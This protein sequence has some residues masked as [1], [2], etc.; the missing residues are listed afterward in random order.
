[1]E[2]LPNPVQHS[3]D[4]WT[5]RKL[6][7]FN[8]SHIRQLIQQSGP[9]Y[10]YR[11]GGL[12]DRQEGGA[13]EGRQYD[14]DPGENWED[15]SNIR[16]P[17]I[18]QLVRGG[19]EA[20]E[21]AAEDAGD[22]GSASGL[23]GDSLAFTLVYV[24]VFTVT[25]L[26]VGVRL[27]RRWRARQ[28]RARSDAPPSPALPPCG[29]PQCARPALLPYTGL[30]AAWIPELLSLQSG[31]PA[32]SPAPHS[33]A[34]C[35]G[36]CSECRALARPPPSYTKLFYD[37]Q[38]PAYQDTIVIKEDHNDGDKQEGRDLDEEITCSDSCV[39]VMEIP[40]TGESHEINLQGEEE[41]QSASG[42]DDSVDTNA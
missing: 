11:P 33:T 41:T 36:R 35:R 26:Y 38:P 17:S 18:E 5:L 21:R 31:Q 2:S 9:L 19:G 12:V 37:E 8:I 40:E 13:E 10:S 29:H 20:T 28:T 3:Q 16:F 30:G 23:S 34:V 39:V 6:P 27:A 42:S 15:E 22:S 25:M 24:S 1:M 32:P 4:G 14:V 7:Y